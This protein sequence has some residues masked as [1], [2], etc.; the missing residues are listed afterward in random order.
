MKTQTAVE[1]LIE[2]TTYDNG[3]GVRFPSW[4]EWTDL[5]N[6]CEQAKQ[7]ETSSHFIY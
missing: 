2:K 5:T 3:Y 7:M 4:N 1:W 6:F